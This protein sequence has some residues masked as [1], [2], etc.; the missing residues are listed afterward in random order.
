MNG[1]ELAACSHGAFIPV[2]KEINTS[3]EYHV[4]RDTIRE[5]KAGLEVKVGAGF[6][7]VSV[8]LF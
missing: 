5:S 1:T 2:E 3:I 4:V 7:L 8:L 6:G